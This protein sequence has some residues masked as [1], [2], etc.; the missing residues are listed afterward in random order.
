MNIKN[1][2]FSMF[3]M[4]AAFTNHIAVAGVS[5]NMLEGLDKVAAASAGGLLG[6]GVVGTMGFAK[7]GA[8]IGG[9]IGGTLGAIL[10]QL[11]VV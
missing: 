3:I 10:E 1:I 2:L 5:P 11:L 6:M 7:G 4:S 8:V 9:W